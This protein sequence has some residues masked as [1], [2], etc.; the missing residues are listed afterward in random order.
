MKLLLKAHKL[1]IGCALAL[2]VLLVPWGVWQWRRTGD[3]TA[4]ILAA[5]ALAVSLAL[6]VY[7]LRVVKRYGRV[8]R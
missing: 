2:A 7:L 6:V 3:T 4:L 1:L 8:G 5:A